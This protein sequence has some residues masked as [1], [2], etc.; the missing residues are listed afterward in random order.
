MLFL[1]YQQ[2]QGPTNYCASYAISTALNMLFGINTTGMDVVKAIRAHQYFLFPPSW[3][4]GWWYPTQHPWPYY[5]WLPD[6]GAITPIQQVRVINELAPLVLE[7]YS[8]SSFREVGGYQ[9]FHPRIQAEARAL[10][11]EEMIQVLRNPN[12]VLLFTY[13]TNPRSPF[14]GHSV[15]LAAYDREKAQFGF[16]NS[17]WERSERDLTWKSIPEILNLINEYPTFIKP[18]FVVITAMP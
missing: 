9:V 12:Q 10:S 14:E 8:I 1:N 16:L 6:G 17:G 4:E 7:K 3:E 11:I 2:Y 18:H 13:G 15:V 5:S